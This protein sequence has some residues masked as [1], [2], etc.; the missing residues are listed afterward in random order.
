MSSRRRPH[1]KQ[2]V[3]SKMSFYD[4]LY[5][6]YEADEEEVNIK[7]SRYVTLCISF[8]EQIKIWQWRSGGTFF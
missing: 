8:I 4:V 3:N 1:K 5:R 2:E 7:L 6:F